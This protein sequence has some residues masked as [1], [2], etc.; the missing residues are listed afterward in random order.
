MKSEQ[1]PDKLAKESTSA[2]K[3]AD[4]W[5]VQSLF[6]LKQRELEKFAAIDLQEVL[7][8]L[9]DGMTQTEISKVLSI[10]QSTLSVG[11]NTL[12]DPAMTKALELARK[13]GADALADRAIQ[14]LDAADTDSSGSCT[15]A[16]LKAKHWQWRAALA[17]RQ[18]YQERRDAVEGGNQ[19]ASLPSFTLTILTGQQVKVEQD[20]IDITPEN[21]N[22]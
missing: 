22:P 2:R 10:P 9:A 15:I 13:A 21:A 19:A 12:P 18:R 5:E 16:G 4:K 6:K 8:M 3:K 1:L 14:A 20:I 17:D 11:L 7:T